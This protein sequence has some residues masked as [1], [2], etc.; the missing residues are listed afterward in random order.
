M[1]YSIFLCPHSITNP[2]VKNNFIFPEFQTE[3]SE[4]LSF[5]VLT[6]IKENC[7]AYQKSKLVTLIVSASMQVAEWYQAYQI[8]KKKS[9]V[10]KLARLAIAFAIVWYLILQT[11]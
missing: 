6:N 3:G 11:K 7:R 2:L 8:I 9:V 1:D 4:T 10:N 5:L